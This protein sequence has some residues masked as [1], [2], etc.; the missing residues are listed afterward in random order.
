MMLEQAGVVLRGCI[1]LLV[2]L[3]M[4]LI[5]A[6]VSAA[7]EAE[8]VSRSAQMVLVITPDWD[9]S[10]AILRPFN[11]VD[12]HWQPVTGAQPVVI[13]KLGSAWGLGLHSTQPGTQKREGDGRA[14]AG[15]F[16]IGSA[17]GYMQELATRLDYLP[18]SAD[19]YCVDV[20]GSVLY[21][22]IVNARKVGANAVAGSTEPM[23]RDLHADGD[24]RYKIG[25]VIE[26]N[27]TQQP[28]RGSCIFAHLWK[29]EDSTTAGCT[30][31]D[32][33]VL[34]ALLDWLDPER[35]P[36]FVLLPRAESERLRDPWQLP[37]LNVLESP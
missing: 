24:L 2:G 28:G 11:R 22:Q 1:R 9:S 8:V 10:R 37:E 5:A 19:D 14:P 33:P 27:V 4:V 12:G 7:N 18:M 6:Q 3:V 16:T 15:I 23:R 36:L 35:D 29:S 32:E 20:S 26:H 34:R 25:F 31:M 13:G 21:N 17:F 30:A